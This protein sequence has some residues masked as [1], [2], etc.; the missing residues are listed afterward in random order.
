MSS[1]E[2]EDV[3]GLRVRADVERAKHVAK[4]TSNNLIWKIPCFNVYFGV[5]RP[6]NV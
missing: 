5:I 6:S 2:D 3:W 4:N 1:N